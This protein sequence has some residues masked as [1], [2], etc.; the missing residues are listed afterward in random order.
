MGK[1]ILL[2]NSLGRGPVYSAVTEQETLKSN[3]FAQ[4]C[5]IVLI[6]GLWRFWVSQRASLFVTTLVGVKVSNVDT[7]N[8]LYLTCTYAE[9]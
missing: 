7:V 6:A 3:G 5:S 2:G 4:T 9:L 8:Q 1:V